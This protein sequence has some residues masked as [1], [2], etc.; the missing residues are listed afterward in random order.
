MDNF[1][2]EIEQ[3]QDPDVLQNDNQQNTKEWQRIS[4]IAILY[5][6]AKFVVGF[7]SNI[8]VF[9]PALYLSYDS[10]MAYPHL[11]LPIGISL[12]ALIILSTFLSFYFF[13][14]RLH[15]DHIEIRSGVISKKYVNLPFAKIQNVKLEQ[16]VYYRP[17][18]FTC[19]QLDTAGSAKQEAK[20]VALKSDFAEQLKK[21]ILAQH[22]ISST[23]VTN[24]NSVDGP[25]ITTSEE[26]TEVI[27]NTRS[28][29]DLVIHG[30]TN[31]RIW[32]FLGGLAPFF[33]DFGRYIIDF[34]KGLGIDLESVLTFADKPMWQIGLYALTLTFLILIP[35]TLFSIA[36]SII[37]FYNF[38]L[39]KVGDRYIRRSGLLTKY[40]VIMRLSRLQMVVRQQ[41]WLDVLLKRINLKFEQSNIALNEYQAGAQNNRIVVPSIH[42]DECLTLVED[43][44]PESAM[45]S[46]NYQNISKRFLLRNLGFIL[47]PMFLIISSIVIIG[48]KADMLMAITPVYLFISLLIFMRWFR[49]GYAKDENFIYIRKGFFGVDYYCFPIY[50]SQQ[51][52]FK[53]S[54]FQKRHQ[55]CSIRIVLA[56]GAQ[57]IP[58]LTE[59]EGLHLLDNALHQVESSRK[60]WM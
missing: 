28:I 47:T 49:W 44:Y 45:M 33:D 10:F 37:T 38:T 55:L 11:W 60:S 31:N 17:F 36:G 19:L 18:G 21:E 50:K 40:E 26:T 58:F 41:D 25:E 16:P 9:L 51:V 30:V 3:E 59:K 24:E 13:Q 34:F 56:A 1:A 35:F 43:V 46:I 14:Y 6:L 39:S 27:L 52:Q 54:W 12:L 23:S 7:L 32:I 48:E 42:A 5:F 22:Q 20:V 4:P 53:Q 29:S 57:D 8:I 15:K 2:Q